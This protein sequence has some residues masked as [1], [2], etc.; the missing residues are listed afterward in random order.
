M[1]RFFA[2]IKRMAQEKREYRQMVARIKALPEEYGFVFH[3]IQQYMWKYAAG[4]A[5]DMMLIFSDLLDIFE[6]GVVN[7]KHVL[8]ITGED[9]AAFCDELLRDT[10][11][12]T[13]K[14]HETLNRDI[15]KKL[16]MRDK[17]T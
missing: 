1:N 14:W 10:E 12:Y 2:Y 17:S 16:G 9:V 15:M 4:S 5:T 13:A 3:K 7:G 6:A 8:E 11:T